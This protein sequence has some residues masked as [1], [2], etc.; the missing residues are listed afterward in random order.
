MGY[1]NVLVTLD[2]TGTILIKADSEDEARSKAKEAEL[3]EM[4]LDSFDITVLDVEDETCE[5]E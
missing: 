1:W 4:Q 2:A 3:H 5:H